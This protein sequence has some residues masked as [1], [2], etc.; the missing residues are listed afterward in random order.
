MKIHISRRRKTSNEKKNRAEKIYST[1]QSNGTHLSIQFRNFYSFLSFHW[2]SFSLLNSHSIWVLVVQSLP[3]E[4][5]SQFRPTQTFVES[6]PRNYSDRS[7]LHQTWDPFFFFGWSH[8][9]PRTL[10]EYN[11]NL[12]TCY[13]NVWRRNLTVHIVNF[14]KTT[15]KCSN[16]DTRGLETLR[17]VCFDGKTENLT[18]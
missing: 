6:I 4:S 16:K 1:Y 15:H 10:Y 3:L 8:Q 14:G 9:T 7:T 5:T 2:G 12:N 18:W 11:E 13:V 17:R